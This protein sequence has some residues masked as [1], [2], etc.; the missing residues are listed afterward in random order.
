MG[1]SFPLPTGFPSGFNRA[2]PLT[3]RLE[4]DAPTI[5]LAIRA[6]SVVLGNGRVPQGAGLGRFGSRDA[7]SV[8][9][10]LMSPMPEPSD[11]C[12]RV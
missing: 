4:D 5:D 6:D 1:E 9:S 11:P 2:F 8:Y 3:V 12:P 7:R 10:R